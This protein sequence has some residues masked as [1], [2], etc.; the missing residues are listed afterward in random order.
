MIIGDYQGLSSQWKKAAEGV[1]KRQY[2]GASYEANYALFQQELQSLPRGSN[3]A[4]NTRINLARKVFTKVNQAF[5]RLVKLPAG[6]QI[7]HSFDQL[8][9]NP[10]RAL[11]AHNLEITRGQAAD[12]TSTHHRAHSASDL[13]AQGIKNPGLQATQE[14]EGAIRGAAG[15]AQSGAGSPTSAA[16]ETAEIAEV[17]EVA[18]ASK[19][20]EV[21]EVAEVGAGGR[22]SRIVGGAGTAVG[23]AGNMAVAAAVTYSSFMVGT[24]LRQGK[25]RE[26]GMTAIALGY[27]LAGVPRYVPSGLPALDPGQPLRPE[28]IQYKRGSRAKVIVPIGGSYVGSSANVTGPMYD[29]LTGNTVTGGYPVKVVYE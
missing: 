1:L 18:E 16:T 4:P 12:L 6:T 5:S 25:Y 10:F 3:R 21:A 2:G 27:G 23:I 29:T 26:A 9:R 7:H 20:A 19:V 22:A 11:D 14:M 24:Y 28:W 17:A 13:H 8:A 15:G